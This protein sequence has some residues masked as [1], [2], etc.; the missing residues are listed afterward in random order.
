MMTRRPL[1]TLNPKEVGVPQKP[2]QVHNE[3][4]S[5]KES[6]HNPKE[7]AYRRLFRDALSRVY[8]RGHGR[9]EPVS[10]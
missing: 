10:N 2:G 6:P 5:G 8:I 4:T 1:Q 7:E 9:D 3:S